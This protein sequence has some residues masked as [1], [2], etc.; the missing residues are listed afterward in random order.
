MLTSL[1]APEDDPLAEKLAA[2]ITSSIELVM[3]LAGGLV[4]KRADFLRGRLSDAALVVCYLHPGAM[5]RLAVKLAEELPAGACVVSHTFALPGW[6]PEAMLRA[7]D[8]H[9]SPI[10]VYR[11][12]QAGAP[13]GRRSARVPPAA[14]RPAAGRRPADRAG[15]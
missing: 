7:A 6:Q 3:R 5:E 4:V 14:G 11:W 10:Y 12:P 9:R 1:N 15:P 8:L 2:T 13:A